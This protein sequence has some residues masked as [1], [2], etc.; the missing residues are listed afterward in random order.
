MVLG[1]GFVPCFPISEEGG[2]NLLFCGNGI[3]EGRDFEGNVEGFGLGESGGGRQ[4]VKGIGNGTRK[5]L[6]FSG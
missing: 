6:L 2:G 1:L 5:V 3:F 4:E